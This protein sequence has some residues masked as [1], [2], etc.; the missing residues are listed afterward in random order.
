M[1]A[2]HVVHQIQRCPSPARQNWPQRT[3]TLSP[4]RPRSGRGPGRPLL[5]QSQE[6]EGHPQVKV[7]PIPATIQ[8]TLDSDGSAHPRPDSQHHATGPSRSAPAT[9]EN[10]NANRT[11]VVPVPLSAQPGEQRSQVLRTFSILWIVIWPFDTR[12]SFGFPAH[13]APE[14]RPVKAAAAEVC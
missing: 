1:Q 8:A 12:T 10:C 14:W 4:G 6:N 3:R 7:E 13:K 2:V 9:H 5:R 11:H